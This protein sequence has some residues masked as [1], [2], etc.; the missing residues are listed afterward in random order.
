MRRGALFR[1]PAAG[2]A[3]PRIAGQGS[4]AETAAGG[5]TVAVGRE[6]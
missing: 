3:T 5:R 1:Q 6:G 4:N 2:V